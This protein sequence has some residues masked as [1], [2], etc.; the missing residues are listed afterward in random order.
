LL[1][2]QVFIDKILQCADGQHSNGGVYIDE[3]S[4]AAKHFQKKVEEL[5]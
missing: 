1:D 2:L 4:S 5:S 3:K